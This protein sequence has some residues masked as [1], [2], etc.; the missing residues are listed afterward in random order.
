MRKIVL[1]ASLVAVVAAWSVVVGTGV[2]GAASG[3]GKTR[4]G[5]GPTPA[6]GSTVNGG[7]VVDGNCVL[8]NV[9]VNGGLTV[10]A[11]GSLSQQGGRING[12]LTNNGGEVDL[13]ATNNGVGFPTGTTSTVNGGV[14]INNGADTDLWTAQ[15][16]GGLAVNGTGNFLQVCGNNVTGQ[17]SFSNVSGA[18]GI[19][20][21][22]GCPGNTF[23]SSL[24]LTSSFI[25]LGG[26]TIGANL[27]CTSTTVIVTAPNT[28]GGTNTCY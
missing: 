11:T 7:L 14:T 12:G 15:I 25:F 3:N 20:G 1:L 27:L 28:I 9:T 18:I 16:N 8:V 26:N 6:A 17:A 2:A 23:G 4:C 22:Y 19:G 5:S 24:S 10:E 21:A 13:N